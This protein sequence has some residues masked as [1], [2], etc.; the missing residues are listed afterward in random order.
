[1]Q[2][3]FLNENQMCGKLKCEGYEAGKEIRLVKEVFF[4]DK[5]NRKATNNIHTNSHFALIYIPNLYTF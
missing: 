1:M 4:L 2:F 3:I 5:K